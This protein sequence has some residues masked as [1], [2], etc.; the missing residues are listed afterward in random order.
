[1]KIVEQTPSRMVLHQKQPGLILFILLWA[2]L[3]AGMP[4][5]VIIAT[6]ANSGVTQLTCRRSEIAQVDCHLSKSHGWGIVPDHPIAI[7]QVTRAELQQETRESDDGA[8]QVYRSVLVSPQGE[9]QL[10]PFSTDSN[11]NTI[12]VNRTNEFL[13]SQQAELT[14][15]LDNRWNV[16]QTIAPILFLSLFVLVGFSLVYATV[17]SQTLILDKSLNRLTYKVWT[18]LGTRRSD[19]P[20]GIVQRV[21]VKEHIDSYGNKSYAPILMPDAVRQI[22]F[23]QNRNR[24]EAL[25]LQ[26]KIQDF[27]NLSAVRPDSPQLDQTESG[28]IVY[29]GQLGTYQT[30]GLTKV[31][32]LSP[33]KVQEIDRQ[34]ARL[35]LTW[36]GDLQLSTLPKILLYPYAHPNK[37]LYAIV[38]VIE[39]GN[40]SDAEPVVSLEFLSHFFNG[41]LLITTSNKLVFPNLKS[42]KIRR[43]SYPGLDPIQLYQ[44]HQQQA[45]ELQSKIGRIHRAKTDLNPI[46]ALLDDYLKRQSTGWLPLMATLINSIAML[47]QS[48]AK[49]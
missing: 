13:Q 28:T 14:L 46:A 36:V 17:R 25:Q 24:Q 12:W 31:P 7:P 42:Q 48:Q 15:R 11:T 26:E 41:T 16:S 10:T 30:S 6:V 2:S 47:S 27:L 35:G 34:L 21:E 4:L 22:S 38:M 20:L 3:F 23:A 37:D 44:Q 1:M 33:P 40:Q 32:A 45:S 29:T 49:R 5:A 8:Y 18:L 9:W 39:L 43:G 19:Y